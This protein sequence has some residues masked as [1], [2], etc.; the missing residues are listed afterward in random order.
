MTIS[1]RRF[2]A[3]VL[4]ALAS[5]VVAVRGTSVPKANE[6]HAFLRACHMGQLNCAQVSKP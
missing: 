2:V 5:M 4:L 3:I 6:T 1:D